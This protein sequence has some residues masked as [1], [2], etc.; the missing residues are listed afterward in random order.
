MKMD[1]LV[2]TQKISC[3]TNNHQQALIKRSIALSP[4]VDKAL[5]YLYQKWKM[6]TSTQQTTK[7]GKLI[8]SPQ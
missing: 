5:K 3:R 7:R 2:L 8:K 6:N 1:Q 4:K